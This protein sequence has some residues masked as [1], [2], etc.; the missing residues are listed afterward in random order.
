METEFKG[1]IW[2][3]GDDIDTDII[4][5]TQHLN[6]PTMEE[7]S[8]HLFEPLRPKLAAQLQKGDIIVA[9]D[10]FGCGSSREQAAELLSYKGVKCIIAKS[11]A[12]IFFRNAIN[13]GVLLIENNQLTDHIKEGDTLTVY[14]NKFISY[15]GVSYPI[16]RIAANLF[17]IIEDGGL[18]KHTQKI[19]GVEGRKA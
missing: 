11:F 16:P 9:G 15:N 2:K 5:P 8:S 12:R 17:E 14:I 13:N 1:R 18:V 3:F 6:L 4:I 7:M 19:N 10:N